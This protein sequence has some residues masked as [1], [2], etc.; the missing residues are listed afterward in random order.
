MLVLHIFFDNCTITFYTSVDTPIASSRW[1]SIFEGW[2]DDSPPSHNGIS[3]DQ[4]EETAEA[5]EETLEGEEKEEGGEEH[6]EEESAEDEQT[7]EEEEEEKGEGTEEDTEEDEGIGEEE[8]IEEEE[9]GDE[10]E[11]AEAEE[12]NGIID[13]ARAKRYEIFLNILFF[14]KRYIYRYIYMYK[15]YPTSLYISQINPRYTSFTKIT[16]YY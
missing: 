4:E 10:D 2:V 7:E 3:H 15:K 13:F 1:A 9:K 12:A 6:E 5:S 16:K 14:L 11:N 8:E